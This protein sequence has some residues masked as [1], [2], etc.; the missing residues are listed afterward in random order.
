MTDP[1]PADASQPSQ[2]SSNVKLLD[3]GDARASKFAARELEGMVNEAKAGQITG[4]FGVVF[5]PGRRYHVRSTGGVDRL[6]AAGALLD[7]AIMQ[8]G[9]RP[10]PEE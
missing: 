2:P 8:L 4:F 5:Q 10:P 6:E 3:V 1:L 7:A 9:Y